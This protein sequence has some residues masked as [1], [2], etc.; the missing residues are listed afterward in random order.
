M[1]GDGGNDVNSG[2]SSG[3]GAMTKKMSTPLR[4]QHH[5]LFQHCLRQQQLGEENGT[6]TESK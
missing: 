4:R 3:G 1:V 2:A 5:Y 6:V